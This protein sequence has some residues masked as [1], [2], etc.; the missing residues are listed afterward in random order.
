[1]DTPAATKQ[2]F[3]A[4][5]VGGGPVGLT[6][7]HTL[8]Q[9]NIDFEL[10][11]ARDT[12]FADEG[13]SIILY[14]GGLAHLRAAGHLGC[15]PGGIVSD[16]VGPGRDLGRQ[17]RPRFDRPVDHKRSAFHR[18]DLVKM[19]HDTLDSGSQKRIHTGKKVVDI[20]STS[21]GVT[22]HCADGTT[23]DGSI[24]I[25]AD[26]VHS[27]TRGFMRNLALKAA[28]SDPGVKVN[29]EKPYTA[30]YRCMVQ[31]KPNPPIPRPHILPA[32]PLGNY[33]TAPTDPS[34]GENH[35]CHGPKLSSMVIYGP[36]RSWFFMYEQLDQPTQERRD[37]TEADMEQYAQQFSQMHL[38]DGVRFEDVW[39]KRQGAGMSDLYEGMVEHWHHGRVVLCGDAAF[40]VTPNIGWGYNSGSHSVVALTNR[41][42]DLV[43]NRDD[44][45]APP[46][47]QQL[48][49]AFAEYGRERRADLGLVQILSS[50]ATRQQA[51]PVNGGGWIYKMAEKLMNLMPSLET[52]MI[53]NVG[54]KA[55]QNG[56]M[57]DFVR[58][59]E[60][61]CKSAAAPWIY[62][63]PTKG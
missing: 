62:P 7:A 55:Q 3:R 49:K 45:S 31:L 60:D 59:G 35:D 16:E 57:L 42:H 34:A 10:L 43:H 20:Q 14:P 17:V 29:P 21:E 47:T 48:S 61:P 9:A 18:R 2:P 5:V 46:T 44:T 22:V 39:P 23:F 36:E 12:V 58:F 37:Y 24:V 41:L 11:E 6:L 1:M 15:R 25:G 38:T 8:A 63:Y 19:L 53:W 50:F 26:G 28:A 30:S 40:K 32:L 13:A 33:P 52:F 56:R 27:K 54:I 4:I 51:W